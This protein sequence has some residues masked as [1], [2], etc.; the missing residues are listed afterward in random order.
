MMEKEHDEKS[1]CMGDSCCIGFLAKEFKKEFRMAALR[2]KE[3]I[4]EA[5]LEFVR[6]MITLMKKSSS[7]PTKEIM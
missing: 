6:E 4:L 5:K 1:C 7:E 2:K 3:K